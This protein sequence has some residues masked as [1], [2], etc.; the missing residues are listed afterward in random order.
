MSSTLLYVLGHEL[1]LLGTGR[2]FVL[3]IIPVTKPINSTIFH[4]HMPLS[5]YSVGSNTFIDIYFVN[6]I[7]P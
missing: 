4:K 3:D 1:K 7:T 5:S 2:D 6:E